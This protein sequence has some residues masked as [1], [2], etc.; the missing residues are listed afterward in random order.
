MME[1]KGEV[2]KLEQT[3]NCLRKNKMGGSNAPI[4]KIV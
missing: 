3:E 2:P 1:M 4:K